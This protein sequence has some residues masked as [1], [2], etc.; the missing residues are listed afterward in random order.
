M[1]E[2][3]CGLAEVLLERGEEE[4][5]EAQL[6]AC[7]EAPEEERS[8]RWCMAMAALA[9]ARGDPESALEW[10]AKAD[11]RYQHTQIPETVPVPARR[12]RILIGLG[13]LEE[14]EAWAEEHGL[15]LQDDAEFLREYELIT[16]ARLWLARLERGEVPGDQIARLL[17]RLLEAA[18]SG[19]RVGSQIEIL[20]LQTRF[21]AFHQDDGAASACLDRALELGAAE[22][23]HGVFMRDGSPLR[24]WLREV[25][26]RGARRA[27]ARRLH[28]AVVGSENT[29]VWH[30][31]SKA[32]SLLGR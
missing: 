17:D 10:L 24:P 13:R 14:V 2:A 3:R 29:P 9:E 20:I 28:S 7:S 15:S 21:H 1:M 12:A 19:D 5:A 25:V 30:S 32:R 8:Y 23:F 27:I 4:D 18:E 16:L 26:A 6:L 11:R 22:R 31:S